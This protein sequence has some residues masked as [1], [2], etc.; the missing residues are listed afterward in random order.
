MYILLT[1]YG[2]ELSDH[3]RESP[4]TKGSQ[5]HNEQKRQRIRAEKRRI[6]ALPSGVARYRRK[7]LH[8]LGQSAILG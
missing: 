3:L 7:G 1:L 6:S 5:H 4:R 8:C 2:I